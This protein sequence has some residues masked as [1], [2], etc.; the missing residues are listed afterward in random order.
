[1]PTIEFHGYDTAQARGLYEAI[2]EQV[3]GL[4]YSADIVFELPRNTATRVGAIDG[5][6][7]PFVRIYSRSPERA[8]ELAGRVA[9]L[10]DVETALIADFS[11]KLAAPPAKV[12]SPLT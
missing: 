7:R 9:L 8:A 2:C 11:Q 3:R 5:K 1:M 10:S 6:D 12:D 4:P